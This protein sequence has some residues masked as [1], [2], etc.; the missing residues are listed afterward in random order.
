M[1]TPRLP[2]FDWTDAYANLNGLVRFARKT[3]YDF[4]VCAITFQLASTLHV[5]ISTNKQF[6]KR[7]GI[8][9][10]LD[11]WG[12]VKRYFL[13]SNAIL[14]VRWCS[15]LRHCATSRKVAGSI[16]N[17]VRFAERQ[18]LVSARVPSRFN[19]PLL[20]KKSQSMFCVSVRP[21]LH[22]DIHIWVTSCWT[23]RML[24]I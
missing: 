22:P 19:W 24:W 20:R 14:R 10:R 2:A 6:S 17:G 7:F 9:S 11:S 21:W 13:I 23:L 5:S 3:K 16:P 12:K 18:N 15:W 4:C 1:P 8:L